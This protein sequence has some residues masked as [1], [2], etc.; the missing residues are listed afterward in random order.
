VR[1]HDEIIRREAGRQGV[2]P[3]L[4]RAIIYAE[5]ARGHYFSA[6]RLAESLG[7][8]DSIF[9]MNINPTLWRDLGFAG[10]DPGDP[11]VNI[12][13]GVTLLRRI[14][15]RLDDPAPEA[16]G[17]LYNSLA[18]DRVTDYGA[19]VGRLVREKPWEK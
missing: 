10:R 17:T 5:N 13:A 6:A 3:D 11:E 9:P 14:R 1:L 15:D 7:R 19:Y 12:R 18:K 4:V 16:I 8:A 2:D